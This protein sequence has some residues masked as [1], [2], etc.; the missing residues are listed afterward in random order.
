MLAEYFGHFGGRSQVR[1]LGVR[2]TPKHI[3][4]KQFSRQLNHASWQLRIGT[5]SDWKES[6]FT[7]GPLGFK[8]KGLTFDPNS[9]HFVRLVPY[10]LEV[11]KYVPKRSFHPFLP[12]SNPSRMHFL[13]F[14]YYFRETDG[15]TTDAHNLCIRFPAKDKD[16]SS[17]GMIRDWRS[18]VMSSERWA[19]IEIATDPPLPA[20]LPDLAENSTW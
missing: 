9:P 17:N 5:Q 10:E 20:T 3:A 19:R 16:L 14:L 8:S 18:R 15:S 7:L 6:R 1:S 13:G 11:N 12:E 4:T 2:V